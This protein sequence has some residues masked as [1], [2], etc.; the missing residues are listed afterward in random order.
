[1][2]AEQ[3]KQLQQAILAAFS[4]EDLRQLVYFDLGQDLAT[5][6]GKGLPLKD[7]VFNLLKW[8]QGDSDETLAKLVEAIQKARPKHAKVQAITQELLAA[9]AG[10]GGGAGNAGGAAVGAGAAPVIGK[11]VDRMALVRFVSGLEPGDFARL[12]IAI[13]DA[14]AHISRA[15]TVPE[16]A[17]ELLRWVE[18]STGPKL[19]ALADAVQQTFPNFR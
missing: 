15:G 19:P 12:V 11:P 18:S 10:G 9:P 2:T 13:P 7:V 3:M 1:M 8:A 6:V 17:A 16:Q 5:I 4:E 14:A